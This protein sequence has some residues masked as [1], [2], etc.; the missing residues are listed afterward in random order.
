[1]A[2]PLNDNEQQ[3]T[4]MEPGWSPPQIPR[5]STGAPALDLVLGGGL[6]RN[7][8][9]IL[10][11]PPGAGKTI[12][13]QQ[14]AFAAASSGLHVIYFTSVSEPH[15]KLI[16]HIRP[17]GFYQEGL[18]G[19]AINIY[20]ISAEVRKQGLQATLDF[21]IETVR[22]E[23]ADVVIVDSFRGL[24]QGYEASVDN[25]NQIFDLASRLALLECTTLLVGEYTP[26]EIL[27]D[28]EFAIADGIVQ[29]RYD[30]ERL[31]QRR[32]LRVIKL[33]GTGYLEGDH[34]FRIT[35]RGIEVYPRQEALPTPAAVEVPEERVASGVGEL[36]DMLSGGPLRASSTLLIG[37]A[38]TGKT[39]LA[40]HFLAAGAAQGERGLM[41][42]FQETPKQ[43]AIRASQFGLHEQLAF[44]NGGTR[45]MA[46]SPV[47]LDVNLA[48]ARIREAV[49][50]YGIQRVVIDSVAELEFAVGNS[51]RFDEFL[52]SLV[53]YLR[54]RGVTTVMTREIT[55]LFGPELTL[56]SRGLSYI[57]D[58][59][60]LLRYIEWDGQLT[61]A[62]TVLK[63]RGSDHDK[64]LRE[65]RIGA[66]AITLGDRFHN[67]R[68]LMT[69]IPRLAQGPETPEALISQATEP[70]E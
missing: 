15:G 70:S 14:L 66:G 41:V 56:G 21:L 62:L 28:P 17:F 7:S 16:T 24:K 26:Q 46:L 8:V 31:Q 33:R 60:L 19:E 50:G 58:N 55:Q 29:L 64:S 32:S 3:Q 57:A 35:Q 23:K 5:L 12:L 61:R 43:L 6:L 51:D 13:A 36:D 9:S 52:A 45:V 10:T 37:S 42:S 65:L 4:S 25:R 68:G 30:T 38:G 22:S 49:E 1:M 27:T 63:T 48:A 69:G 2:D 18:I 20:N 39:L 34:T 11:G 53:S 67:L 54:S 59:I 47:E 40:L 44:E